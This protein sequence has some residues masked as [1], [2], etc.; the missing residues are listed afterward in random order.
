MMNL[1]MKLALGCPL[2]MASPDGT[3]V[4][5]QEAC[6]KIGAKVGLLLRIERSFADL[7]AE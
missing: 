6:Q 7:P 3:A 5:L 1:S 4:P 2:A